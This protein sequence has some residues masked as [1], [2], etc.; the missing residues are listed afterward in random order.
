MGGARAPGKRPYEEKSQHATRKDA[1]R[2]PPCREDARNVHHRK[3]YGHREH[4]NPS[5]CASEK[6]QL[7]FGRQFSL[8]EPLAVVFEKNGGA[9]IESRR[10]RAHRGCNYRGHEQPR[11]A[12]RQTVDDEPRKH[13]VGFGKHVGRHDTW[14]TLHPCP[15]QSADENEHERHR[16]VKQCAAHHG[17][18]RFALRPCG[19]IPLRIRL[20][21]PEILE[22]EEYSVYERHPKSLDAPIRKRKASE[23]DLPGLERTC[24]AGGKTIR[25]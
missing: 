8:R 9:G 19:D 20:V 16:N 1:L 3:R 23:R 10:Y 25:Q 12:R 13:G 18:Y 24:K 21:N 6:T 7:R 22:I 11:D 2:R 4:G 15:Q 5:G 17:L 14:R